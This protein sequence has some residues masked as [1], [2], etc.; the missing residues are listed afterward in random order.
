MNAKQKFLTM[1][2]WLSEEARKGLVFNAYGN[3]PMSINVICCEIK[4][5]T[6]MGKRLLNKLGF[7]DD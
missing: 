4:A 7:K 5:N 1:F 2:E 3:N 6:D